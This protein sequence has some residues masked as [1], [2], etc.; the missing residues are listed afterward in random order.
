M[1]ALAL[2]TPVGLVVWSILG[3]S[4][5]ELRNLI[6]SLPALS[7][8]IA[9]VVTSGPRPLTV[10]ATVLV[11]AG[12]AIAGGEMLKHNQQRPDSLAAARYI[13]RTAHPRDPVVDGF[14]ITPG[15][16]TELEAALALQ[17]GHANQPHPLLRLGLPPLSAV[18][19]APPYANL[20]TPDGG[21]IA[22]QAIQAAVY[23]TIYLFTVGAPTPAAL[24]TIRTHRTAFET[25]PLGQFLHA[26]P[27]R[28]RFVRW[29]SFTHGFIP[30]SVYTIAAGSA[31][32]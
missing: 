12:F 30:V 16:P 22:R 2:A 20:P 19:A 17:P 15:P 25:T 9:A 1:V 29:R 10:I 24:Q 14:V 31:S 7:V 21:T 3:D 11:L 4:I 6:A 8:L 27:P 28:F 26:L 18:L 5:W 32:H 13:D 23:G